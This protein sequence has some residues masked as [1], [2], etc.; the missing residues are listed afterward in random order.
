MVYSLLSFVSAAVSRHVNQ[1]IQFSSACSQTSKH[2]TGERNKDSFK[3]IIELLE[4]VSANK[5]MKN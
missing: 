1:A 2:Q 5:E 3:G 4:D